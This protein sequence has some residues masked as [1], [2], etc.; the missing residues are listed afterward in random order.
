MSDL[1]L[2]LNAERQLL[3]TDRF[4]SFPTIV[5]RCADRVGVDLYAFAAS[6]VLSGKQ[7]F[8]TFELFRLP[9][10]E[11]VAKALRGDNKAAKAEFDRLAHKHTLDGVASV[12]RCNVVWVWA[13]IHIWRIYVPDSDRLVAGNPEYEL[14]LNSTMSPREIKL[15]I[16]KAVQ[17][18]KNQ[19]EAAWAIGVGWSWFQK[20]K[21]ALGTY[22]Q[23]VKTIGSGTGQHLGKVPISKVSQETKDKILERIV[24][25]G[26]VLAWAEEVGLSRPEARRQAKLLGY[27][28]S[29]E[30]GSACWVR[31]TIASW[32]SSVE[33]TPVSSAWIRSEVLCMPVSDK[34]VSS[35]IVQAMHDF[36][37]SS[38]KL[39]D[40]SAHVW[41]RKEPTEQELILV[42][43]PDQ[44]LGPLDAT[45][46]AL[47]SRLEL[48]N[49][50][51]S[52]SAYPTVELLK[53]AGLKYARKDT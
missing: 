27:N 6:L 12:L 33:Y 42:D 38:E 24:A 4:A 20:H 8:G 3:E 22:S 23:H 43:D 47:A 51:I 13:A 10:D 44:K 31:D 46:E 21:N 7:T 41:I 50:L 28:K 16:S 52:G 1:E 9:N 39:P 35:Y 34:N 5:R 37:F 2:V 26:S 36:G 49:N 14:L 45:P 19:N 15:L 17:K 48:R 25:C 30:K 11:E 29:L 40:G 18:Y 53:K 32:L